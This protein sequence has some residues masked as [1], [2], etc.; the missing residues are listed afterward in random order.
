MGTVYILAGLPGSGKSTWARQYGG[1][2]STIVSADHFFERSGGK[3]NFDFT[4]LGE[5]HGECLKSFVEALIDGHS[6]VFVDNTNTTIPEIAL[7]YAL[8]RAY[9]YKVELH[10][11]LCSEEVSFRRN[12]HNVPMKSIEMMRKRFDT[13]VDNIPTYWDIAVKHHETQYL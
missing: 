4:K 11:F 10:L 8:A 3:Y 5:A 13:L 9:G 7:Y 6:Y 2:M 1:T 12:I